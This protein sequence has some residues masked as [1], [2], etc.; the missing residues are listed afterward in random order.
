MSNLPL[1]T[2]ITDKADRDEE[3]IY[4]FFSERFGEQ[5]AD[6]FREKIIQLFKAL[7]LHPFAGRPAK[8]NKS[9]R[10]FVISR[11]NKLAYK[12]TETEIIF[13]RNSTQKRRQLRD[14]DASPTLPSS[15]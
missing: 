7:S 8:N 15:P 12:L 2:L 3:N 9:I 5:Y 10:V 14:I 4:Q 1:K 6:K 13:L 11:Q